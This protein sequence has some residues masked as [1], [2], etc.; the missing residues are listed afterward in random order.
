MTPEPCPVP[1]VIYTDGGC[2]GNPGVGGWGFVLIHLP[3][4]ATLEE[5]GGEPNT[6][7]NRME[8]SAAI[9]GLE[10]LRKPGQSVEIRT[11]S[12][13][14]KDMAETWMKGWK[15]KGWTKKGGEIKNLD[16]VKALD[17]LLAQHT[18]RWRW[19]P[20]HAGE[21]GNEHADMLTNLAMD[22]VSGGGSANAQRR[23]S[24]PPFV[25]PYAP[26]SPS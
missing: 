10:A 6:T 3:T 19:V 5:R 13:Y 8:L 15:R 14:L 26:G 20:G 4:G 16:L 25:V 11:D 17:V 9:R 23:L 18:V 7:N 1:L 12:K 24:A 2:R 21:P 22:A